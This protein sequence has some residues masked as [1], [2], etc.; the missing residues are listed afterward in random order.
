M[1]EELDDRPG[2]YYVSVVDGDRY[3]L[4]SGPYHR[5]E[6]ALRDVDRVRAVAMEVARDDAVWAAWGTARL[7][8]EAEAPLG[9]LQ[10]A[11]I[12]PVPLSEG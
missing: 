7:P 10:K 3:G 12:E 1:I 2:H 6:A 8:L 5:H 11:G 9:R 4:V